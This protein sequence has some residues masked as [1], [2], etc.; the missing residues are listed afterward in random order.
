MANWENFDPQLRLERIR[1][2]NF[3]KIK[4]LDV[5]IS[6][7]KKL[8]CLVGANGGGKSALL[9]VMINALREL[10]YESGPDLVSKTAVP[11]SDRFARAFSTSEIGP[12]GHGYVF[13][14]DWKSI[15]GSHQY[16]LLTHQPE[17]PS[18][19]F[20]LQLRQELD[21][22]SSHKWIVNEWKHRPAYSDPVAKS[23]FLF[24]PTERFETP[25]YEEYEKNL[26]LTPRLIAESCRDR[27]VYPIRA[28]SALADVESL[29]L[30]VKLDEKMGN[31]YA[32]LALNKITNTLKIFN[33]SQEDFNIRPWPFRRVGIGP[34]YSLSLLSAGELDILVTVGNIIAQQVY[35]SRK[36]IPAE[37][38][39]TMPSGWVFIDEVEAHLQP[40]WQRKILPIFLELFPTIHFMITTH[41]PFVLQSLVHDSS[42][43]IRLPD[44]KVFEED[45][46]QWCLED[47][48]EE[49]FYMP[50]CGKKQ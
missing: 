33:I 42:L 19:E 26:S 37:D 31:K 45:F 17:S 36:F 12:D 6:P 43:V 11:L 16:R 29:I 28:A 22:S 39:E 40:Q 7:H 50:P 5:H 38:N 48:L 8:I 13:L 4:E 47:I 32:Q 44:G 15:G 1:V 24:R 25:Y 18:Q 21:I 35:L 9:S 2:R 49:V 20:L 27:R 10:T 23:V 30:E 34:L 41:S 46:S 14:M 3:R